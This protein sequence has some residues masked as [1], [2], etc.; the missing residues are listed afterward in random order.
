[1]KQE[2]LERA[3][4]LAIENVASQKGG[5]FGAVI[6]KDGKIIAEGVNRVTVDCDPTAH[7]EIGAIRAAAKALNNF[8][9]DGCEIYSSCEPCPMCF[10]AIYWAHLDCV[11]FATE[12]SDAARAGFDD[13]F[14]YEE[15]KKDPG[16]RKIPFKKIE[17][18]RAKQPFEAWMADPDRNEY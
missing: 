8:H 5:P 1:M 14:I 11:Y 17:L 13:A 7:A 9:L 18:G 16:K 15:L 10:S 12:A 3:I 4:N 6:V 2:F